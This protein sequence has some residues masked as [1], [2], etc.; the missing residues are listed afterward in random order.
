MDRSPWLEITM[1]PLCF[2]CHES[3][4]HGHHSYLDSMGFLFYIYEGVV[5]GSIT[6]SIV[7]N[8]MGV[9]HYCMSTYSWRSINTL[10]LS[11]TRNLVDDPPHPPSC[12]RPSS[13]WLINVLC[14][15]SPRDSAIAW[16]RFLEG[17]RKVRLLAARICLQPLVLRLRFCFTSDRC[18]G[19]SWFFTPDDQVPSVPTMTTDPKEAAKI[20]AKYTH[21]RILVIGR[22][23]AGKTTLL[24]R[25]CNTKE[26]PV[27]SEVTYP[28]RL[29]HHAHCRFPN[30]LTL[31]QRCQLS[32]PCIFR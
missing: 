24:K 18:C 29:I 2:L 21:F 16:R 14:R 13:I 6:I 31:P 22:A 25:V 30:R 17:K 28:L 8:W 1:Y 11:R 7:L 3:Y 20:R 4:L 23:N 10:G 5:K 15:K 9:V 12:L 19:P 26:D 32:D 27:Y